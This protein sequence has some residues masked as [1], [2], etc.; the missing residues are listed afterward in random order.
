MSAQLIQMTPAMC[1]DVARARKM[2]RGE[3]EMDNVRLRKELRDLGQALA[4][5]ADAYA[6][7]RGREI[8]HDGAI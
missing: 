1:L 3:L 6:K 7:L 5:T 8:E 2:N 4:T